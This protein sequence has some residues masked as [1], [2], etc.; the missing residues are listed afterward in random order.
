MLATTYWNGWY[1]VFINSKLVLQIQPESRTGYPENRTELAEWLLSEVPKVIETVRDGTYNEYVRQNLPYEKRNGKILREDYWRIDPEVKTGC[2][3]RISQ[4]EIAHFLMLSEST[5]EKPDGRI[6]EMTLRKYLDCCR[7]GYEVNDGRGVGVLDAN[8]LYRSNADGRDQ[9]LLELSPDSADEFD[10]WY[11]SDFMRDAHPWE[12]F[13]GI[14]LFAKKDDDGWW[15][16]LSGSKYL[17]TVKTVKFYL[18]LTDAGVPVSM[19]QRKE[20]AD[21]L[22][23]RDHIGIVTENV[24]PLHCGSIFPDEIIL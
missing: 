22:T 13:I 6:P 11:G 4:E 2:L 21:I 1:S 24:F 5:P 17:Q 10:S 3:E 18:A 9:G 14:F 16:S 15:L 19:Y 23:G 20:M 7:L 8:G 12:V